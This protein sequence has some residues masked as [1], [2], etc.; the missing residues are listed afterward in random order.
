LISILDFRSDENGNESD[1]NGNESD[2]NGN[3]NQFQFQLQTY[4]N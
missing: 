4:G 1:E 3:E 2:E